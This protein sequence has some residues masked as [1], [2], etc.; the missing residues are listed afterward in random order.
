MKLTEFFESIGP[1]KNISTDTRTLTPGDVFVALRG[2]QFDGHEYIS[3]AVSRGA[4][5]AIVD[6]KVDVDVP[7]CVV[8]DTL[9]AYGEIARM[10]REKMPAKLVALTGSCGKTTAKNMLAE[11]FARAGETHATDKNLNNRIGVPQT[12]L[13]ITPDHRWA[14]IE[15]GASVPD[16]IKHSAHIA[17]PDIALIT[18]VTLQH[19]EGMGDLDDIAREKGEILNALKK[20]G[21]AVLPKDDEY[22]HYWES[23]LQGQE[24]ITFGFDP[25]S[26]V[27]ATKLGK[28]DQGYV[29]AEIKTPMGTFNIQLNLL[30]RHNIY[31]A[32]AS[33]AVAVAAGLPLNDIAAGLQA[34]Q[35]VDKRL[36]VYLG[37]N[38][39]TL[40]DDCYNASPTGIKAALEVLS[41][42]E[43]ERLWVFADMKE[44]GSYT[45]E[46]HRE[47]GIAAK[48]LGIDEIFAIGEKAHLTLEAFGEGG[49]HFKD[50]DALVSA[51]KPKLHKDM[52]VLVK[53]SRGNKL[54]TVVA[55]L[56]G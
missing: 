56:K 28:N 36:T 29:N 5:A 43:G 14:V 30:G 3:Q 22:F 54:E 21:S 47:V 24:I 42:Y 45:D 10:H 25:G 31:N 11:I 35:P 2:E 9:L 26:D 27:T 48:A 20:N 16:E 52:T 46:S 4:I 23:L 12:I 17:T 34:M 6:C 38:Q 55:A 39:S 53:G 51:L 40:I 15:L 33:A 8:D 37:I 50:K 32:L 18:M 19:P 49:Q 44:L 41:Q 1:V 13:Q 7:Q